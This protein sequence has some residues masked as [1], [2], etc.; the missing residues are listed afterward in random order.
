MFH[1]IY[2][3]HEIFPGKYLTIKMHV[4]VSVFEKSRIFYY[5]INHYEFTWNSRNFEPGSC[6][7]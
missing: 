4:R 1:F 5:G 3:K 2:K 6:F 7:T